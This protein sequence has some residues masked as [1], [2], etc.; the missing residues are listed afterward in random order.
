MAD[1][2][3]WIVRAGGAGLARLLL[4]LAVGPA[5]AQVVPQ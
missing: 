5:G 4:G 3:R 1:A 2:R